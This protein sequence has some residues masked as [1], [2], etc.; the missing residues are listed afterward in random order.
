MKKIII[1]PDSFKGTLSSREAAENISDAF[2]NAWSE[3]ETI[4]IPI[5]DGGEGTVD[6][7]GSERVSVEVTGPHFE[8]VNSFYGKLGDTAIIELAAAAG[9]P[10]T[11]TLDPEKTTTYGVG[12]L[13]LDAL[14]KGFRKFIVG[15]GG[16]STNDCGCGFAAALGIKF[17][18]SLGQSFIPVGG[19]LD[20]VDRIDISGIDIRIADCDFTTMCDIDNPLYGENGAAYVFAPQ[21]GADE[22]AVIR[23]DNGLRHSAE[24]I[25]RDLNVDVASIPGGGAAGGC[26]AGMA[27]FLSSSLKRGIDVVLDTAKFDDI[28]KDASLVITGEGKFDSQSAGGKAVSGIAARTKSAGVPLVVLAGAAEESQSSYEMGVDAVFSI[29]RKALPLAEAM[30]RNKQDMYRTAY[31]IANLLKNFI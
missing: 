23:L 22:Q 6:A 11:S 26:G 14:D 28:I 4:C 1:C 8:K 30:P 25:K 29:Q 10:M 5:A 31:N 7:F 13:I 24:V 2:K 12:E 18:N 16:S 20:L 9:L 15:L 27:A 19:T 3:Y 17:Y 21:K